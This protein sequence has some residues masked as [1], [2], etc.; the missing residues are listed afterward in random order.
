MLETLYKTN[1]PREVQ[2]EQAEYYELILDQDSV[3]GQMMYFVREMHGWRSEEQKRPIHNLK[4]LSPEE[5]YAS[6]DEAYERHKA[7]RLAR[8]NSGFV[9]SFPPHYYGEGK[10]E[11]EEIQL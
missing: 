8:A 3:N 2:A 7:Q 9:H 6:W 4:T 11:Y 1:K 5:G 10:Y